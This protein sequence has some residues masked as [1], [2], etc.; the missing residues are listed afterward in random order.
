MRFLW[1]R[2]R[3][4]VHATEDEPRVREVLLW[5]LGV[6]A[7]PRAADRISRKRAK[8]LH[9]NEIV[10]LEV[11]LTRAADVEAAVA[12]LFADAAAREAVLATVDRR[13]DD[14]AVLHVRFDKQAAVQRR[15]ALTGGGDAL[16]VTTKAAIPSGEST[17]AA[18]TAQLRELG[19]HH[20]P[21]TRL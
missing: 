6:E 5:L 19:N 16:V 10:V 1:V 11:V 4:F 18:W 8:G 12:R 9:G 14:D 7:S 13:L 15:R 17:S 21:P 2:A 3:T 20:P